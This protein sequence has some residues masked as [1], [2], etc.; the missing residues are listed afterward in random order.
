MEENYY[1]EVDI[2]LASANRHYVERSNED[3]AHEMFIRE[4]VKN[5]TE[6]HEQTIHQHKQK[7]IAIVSVKYNGYNKL[8]FFDNACGMTQDVMY[9]QY[10]SLGTLHKSDTNM[11]IGAKI[12]ALPKNK[13][14][15]LYINFPKNY[16]PYAAM[17]Y[18]NEKKNCYTVRKNIDI[19]SEINKLKNDQYFNEYYQKIKDTGHGT[20]VVLLGNTEDEDTNISPDKSNNCVTWISDYIYSRFDRFDDSIKVIVDPQNNNAK[21]NFHQCTHIVKGAGSIFNKH[22]NKG[23]NFI[24]KIKNVIGNDEETSATIEYG[25][26]QNPVIINSGYTKLSGGCFIID[27]TGEIIYNVSGKLWKNKCQNFGI[28]YRFSNNVVVRITITSDNYKQNTHRTDLINKTTNKPID[29]EYLFGSIFNEK[30][31]NKMRDKLEKELIE[32]EKKAARTRENN[33]LARTTEVAKKLFGTIDFFEKCV[34]GCESNNSIIVL[35]AIRKYDG[36]DNDKGKQSTNSNKNGKGSKK[37]NGIKS[38]NSSD[39][40]NTT[41]K[42]LPL[43]HVLPQKCGENENFVVFNNIDVV[44]EYGSFV[45]NVDHKH[46]KHLIKTIN[47]KAHEANEKCIEKLMLYFTEKCNI[48][49]LHAFYDLITKNNKKQMNKKERYSEIYE[50]LCESCLKGAFDFSMDEIETYVKSHLSRIAK[51]AKQSIAA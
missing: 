27:K 24:E 46:F 49:F 26:L 25:W 30:M 39:C 28:P 20:I 42:G 37:T 33:A 38:V 5:S 16:K 4:I 44:Y 23:S 12:S 19:N 6:A 43:P 21:D 31:S 32:K 50:T 15:V 8:A 22:C 17:A 9:E 18:L 47:E 14:G 36:I 41:R 48:L 11:G 3:I 29:Y 10:A 45:I 40:L 34:N 7:F 35:G 2:K 1:E 13:K 51:Q